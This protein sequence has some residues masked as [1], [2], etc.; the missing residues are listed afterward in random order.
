MIIMSNEGKT[1]WKILNIN[2]E[3]ASVDVEYTYI[4]D[5][6]TFKQTLYLPINDNKTIIGD[7]LKNFISTFGGS[8]GNPEG[9]SII[10]V[11]ET[12]GT[13]PN[14]FIEITRKEQ[15]SKISNW[16]DGLGLS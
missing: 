15:A 7:E 13:Q 2:K 1:T 6:T 5:Q 14:K 8:H 3:L 10:E 4:L 9:G 16:V 11:I 12:P